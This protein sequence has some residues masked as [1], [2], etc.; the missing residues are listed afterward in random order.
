MRQEEKP[1]CLHTNGALAP[2]DQG[3]DDQ[4]KAMF[5]LETS[6]YEKYHQANLLEP[7][8]EA[9]HSGLIS[10]PE[11]GAFFRAADW[12]K[13]L[14]HQVAFL[15]EIMGG[16]EMY[17]G[18]DMTQAHQHL[19]IQASHFDKVAHHLHHAMIK[20][21]IETADRELLLQR[22]NALKAQ[23]VKQPVSVLST[24]ACSEQAYRA[25]EQA[26]SELRETRQ[27]LE[28]RLD[29]QAA[30]IEKLQ[31]L[32]ENQH[33]REQALSDLLKGLRALPQ[34]SVHSNL[35]DLIHQ[36]EDLIQK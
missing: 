24:E 14:K 13:L 3:K 6:L 35:K 26:S 22:V 8:V 9:F 31:S 34:L 21:G 11:L 5:S 2:N 25:L 28:S 33:Q 18:M 32:I 12:D 36:L 30:Q 1:S 20:V 7:L 29:Q 15:S 27:R 19:N 17:A 23:I 16:P 4:W 10:D